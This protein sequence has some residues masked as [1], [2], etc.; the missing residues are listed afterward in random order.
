M[1]VTDFQ[2]FVKKSDQTKELSAE[3]RLQ[4]ALKGLAS[5]IGSV[6]S[7]VKKETLKEGGALSSPL[8]KEEL[9][10]ELG[11]V[12]WYV[13]AAAEL[14]KVGSTEN[15]L[16]SD[17]QALRRE[18]GNDGE[19]AR[20]IRTVLTEER[21]NNFLD[22]AEEFLAHPTRTLNEYQQVAR[23]TART[24]SDTLLTVCVAVLTQLGAQVMR[25][26]LPEVEKQLNKQLVDRDIRI[27]LAEIIWH[28]SAVATLYELALDDVATANV[29][30]N[31]LRHLD[32]EPTPLHDNRHPA[33]ERF[34]RHIVI[35]IRSQ[36][37]KVSQMYWNGEKLGDPLR[38][39]AYEPDGYR[40][41][42]A[43][44]QANLAHL[45]WSPVLRKLMGLKRRSCESLDDVEDGG[46]AA[47]V[48][49]A[50]V[51]IIHA[52]AAWRAEYR[53]P[54]VPPEDRVLF[55][56]DEAIPFD[57]IKQIQR[58][59]FGHEAH[60]N[61]AWEWEA[62]IRSGYYLFQKLRE[63]KGGTVTLNLEE[64]TV[65]FEPPADSD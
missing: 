20:N 22:R 8:A 26:L 34:P 30:K 46:R 41:H 63:H 40:F 45:G 13:F 10:E 53:Q 23:L 33:D 60:K 3:T 49:E 24:E 29:N 37:D 1:L 15:V 11:D 61:K 5:E 52:E 21:A 35:E 16:F 17:I 28:V 58:L 38:D 62:A 27:I 31:R 54:L 44:H 7:A 48:E 51:K 42:D 39:N 47:V 36:G 4:I 57:L 25:H 32:R 65:H 55:P 18:I 50:I 19:R 12:L 59:A 56:P 64:R 2:E 14:D 6:V 43:M 9:K